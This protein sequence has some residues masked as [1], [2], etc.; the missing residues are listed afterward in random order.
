MERDTLKSIQL[1]PR[2]LF[3]GA[4]SICIPSQW[5]DVSEIRQVPDNQEVFQDCTF[6]DGSVFQGELGIHGSGGCI[7]IEVL[8]REDDVSDD[9]AAEFYYKD[10]AEANG[11]IDDS[12]S[13]DDIGREYSIDYL[14]SWTVGNVTNNI[15]VDEENNNDKGSNIM[16]QLS[17]KTKAFT[18]IGHQRVSPLR[19]RTTL[20]EGKSNVIKVEL[21]VL[22][23]E[24][25]HTDLLISLSLPTSHDKYTKKENAHDP[26]FLEVL[27]SF[28]V[29]D[30]SLFG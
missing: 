3:G 18:C 15:D 21:C 29:L 24:Q 7:V 26:L 12:N 27:R 13:R 4:M 17:V 1:T 9:C 30:W 22:R 6:A 14:A 16:P 10:L 28:Q 2:P 8:E 23:L 5:R 20:E 19:N 11:S 25:V